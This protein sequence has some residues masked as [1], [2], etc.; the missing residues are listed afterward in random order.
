MLNDNLSEIVWGGFKPLFV[1]CTLE[2]SE[3]LSL[4]VRTYPEQWAAVL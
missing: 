4:N 1:T 2:Y 3:I